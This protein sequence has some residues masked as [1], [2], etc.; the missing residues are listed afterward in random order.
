MDEEKGFVCRSW[1]RVGVV[2][3]Y[4]D[5]WERMENLEEKWQQLNLLTEKDCEILVDEIALLEEI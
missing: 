1:R 4:F 3:P 2:F 5:G